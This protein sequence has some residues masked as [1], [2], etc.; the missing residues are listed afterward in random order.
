MRRKDV[1]IIELAAFS[2]PLSTR[3]RRLLKRNRSTR[4]RASQ[5]FISR[6]AAKATTVGLR[7]ETL[8]TFPQIDKQ[9]E[10]L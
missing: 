9:R 6:S 7:A 10:R 1:V 3:F 8:S 2:T 4:G 5:K